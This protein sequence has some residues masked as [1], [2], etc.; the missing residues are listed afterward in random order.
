[1]TQ[2]GKPPTSDAEW[3]RNTERRVAHLE[4]PNTVRIGPWVISSEDG[5]LIATKPGDRIEFGQLPDEDTVSDVTRGFVTGQIGLIEESIGNPNGGG[6]LPKIK[7][8]LNGKW[9]DLV[10]TQEIADARAIAGNNLVS[11]PGFNKPGF[12]LGDGVYVTDL[13]RT[14]VQAARMT[15]NGTLKRIPLTCN[16]GGE[17]RITATAGDIFYVEAWVWGASGNTQTSGGAGGIAIYIDVFNAAGT[18]L[19]TSLTTTG[20]AASN[21]LNNQWTKFVGYITIPTDAPYSAV[22]TMTPYIILNTNVTSGSVYT[23]DD[24]IIRVDSLVNS[25][26]TIYDGANGTT[27]SVGKR[28]SDLFTPLDNLRRTALDG[29]S[30]ASGAMNTALLAASGASGAWGL[31]QGTIDAIIAGLETAGFDLTPGGVQTASERIRSSLNTLSTVT[32]NLQ[33]LEDAGMF[34]GVALDEPMS[35]YEIASTLPGGKWTQA[36]SG[37]GSA[38]WSV[39]SLRGD[40]SAVMAPV[41]GVSSRYVRARLNTQTATQYQRVGVVFTSIG[42]GGGGAPSYGSKAYIF[43]RMSADMTQYVYVEFQPDQVLIG[44]NNGGGDIPISSSVRSYAYKAGV[45]YWL[46]CGLSAA[47][48]YTYKLWEGTT[49]IVVAPD[50]TASSPNS[51]TN[52]LGAGFGGYL[53]DDRYVS[54]R[55]A[56]FTLLDNVPANIRGMG[57]KSYCPSEDSNFNVTGANGDPDTGFFPTNWYGTTP[58]Y[59]TANML[60]DAS[61]NTLTVSEPG[62]YLVTIA[63]KATYDLQGIG[64]V[65]GRVSAG[66]FVDN[67]NGLFD[68]TIDFAPSTGWSSSKESFGGV[69]SVYLKGG[70]KIRPGWKS[71]WTTSGDSFIGS[72]EGETYWSVTFI[73]NRYEKI[74]TVE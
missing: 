53:M 47:S 62:H 2:P 41:S 50:Y 44:F 3:A 21:A 33:A 59:C 35:T 4:S 66:I 19:G 40:K 67:G 34:Y 57:F 58:E 25:W 42:R 30:G 26:S 5:T 65:S 61:T 63:Q 22:A 20:P 31:A 12:Y 69:F 15:A 56:G 74:T 9:D 43:G 18:K 29:A 16:A 24:P 32:A 54:A 38:V 39:A 1:M 55:V 71:W 11:N 68:E 46:E 72:P 17:I 49:P 37:G 10:E 36:A 13:K 28:P 23:F 14:G 51:P 8:F 27:G 73:H 45:P 7:D 60:Y 52:S 64:L 6:G 48:P 70:W